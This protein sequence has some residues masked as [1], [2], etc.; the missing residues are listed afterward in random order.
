MLVQAPPR[1]PENHE[2]VPQSPTEE[3][4]Q[5]ISVLAIRLKQRAK[6]V[7][8]EDIE[9]PAA[10]HAVLQILQRAGA[11]TVPQI[12]RERSTSRQNI[13]VLVDRLEGEGHV[14]LV[15]NPAHKRSALVRLTSEG[16]TLLI[17]GDRIQRK[18]FS[19]IESSLSEA[20]IN[21][22][23]SVLRKVQHLLS[24]ERVKETAQRASRLTRL[25]SLPKKPKAIDE[26][27]NNQ[28]GFP[29]NLL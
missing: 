24:G 21:A 25:G 10:E 28:E 18:V 20:E 1:A 19:E 27:G 16:Q 29:V 9:L 7:H 14:E 17:A 11:L 23:V 22:A 4:I 26:L 3:L 15:G 12:A 2:T 13:Q 6:G 8:G 5:Q